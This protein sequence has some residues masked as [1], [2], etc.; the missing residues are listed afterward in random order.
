MAA[1]NTVE[2]RIIGKNEAGNVIAEVNGQ[3]GELGTQSKT[4]AA[5][6][7]T[8]LLSAL[9]LAQQAFSIVSDAIVGSINEMVEYSNSVQDTAMMLG[10][11]NE[12]ASTLI[13][14]ADDARIS[15]GELTTAFRN[16]AQDGITPNLE[17]LVQLGEQYKAIEDPAERLA[18]VMD[19][20]GARGSAMAR[21]LSLSSEEIA[22]M[23]AEAKEAGLVMD[24]AMVE[25]AEDARLAMDSMNDS[26]T[27]LK[28]A[29]AG[30]AGPTFSAVTDSL[31]SGVRSMT[32]YVGAT[33]MLNDA[34]AAGIVTQEQVNDLYREN[35]LTGTDLAAAQEF[36][37]QATGEVTDAVEEQID[38][39]EDQATEARAAVPPFENY[40]GAVMDA[41]EAAAYWAAQAES[42]TGAN[43]SLKIAI[44][45]LS[46]EY[47]EAALMAGLLDD[48]LGALSDSMIQQQQD[49]ALLALLTGELS[50][51]EYQA[52]MESIDSVAVMADMVT[53]LEDGT[54]GRLDYLAAMSDGI[55]TQ[56]EFDAALERNAAG[57]VQ[58]TDVMN[59]MDAA[60]VSGAIDQANYAALI[61]DGIVTQEELDAAIATNIKS[62]NHMAT[63]SEDAASEVVLSADAMASGLAPTADQISG[64][65]NNLNQIDG[66]D[67]EANVTITTTGG[68]GID[69]GSL[70]GMEAAS[71]ANFVVPDGYPNDSFPLM[72]ESGEHVQVTPAGMD[73]GAPGRTYTVNIYDALAAK[74]W[75]EQQRVQELAGFEELMG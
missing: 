61:S 47:S 75:M 33:K 8:D 65:L 25:N 21:I 70:V 3:V 7:M 68:G 57:I 2:I 15:V 64:I 29:F 23:A 69:L 19:T 16:A 37:A 52:R 44:S 22:N 58:N 49:A 26:V 46:G 28:L 56:A 73:T 67:I 34:V 11:T 6:G 55:V 74:M 32:D 66:M 62:Y 38:A 13:Q 30:L 48:S 45:D 10:I 43:T 39:I 24:D 27:G 54:I 36:L 53:A 60:L 9:T 31:A 35:W 50:M 40:S 18:F 12:E 72:V 41:G 4:T 42:S 20:F 51:A 17:T 71:G 1:S 59:N 14:V 63:A 5:G